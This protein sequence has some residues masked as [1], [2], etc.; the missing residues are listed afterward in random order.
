ML[1]DKIALVERLQ[2]NLPST[3]KEVFVT[4]S[5]IGNAG[6]I[7]IN[8]QPASPELTAIAD[9]Q[10]FKTYKAFTTVSGVT[11]TMRVTVSGT[12]QRYIVR[13]RENYDYGVNIHNELTLTKDENYGA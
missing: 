13:G 7:A 12:T 3:D 2:K 10:M 11:E 4:A 8:I 1:L 9:G 5:G 6:Y